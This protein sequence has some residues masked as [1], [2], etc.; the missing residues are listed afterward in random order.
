LR[1]RPATGARTMTSG[2]KCLRRRARRRASRQMGA[3]VHSPSG[4]DP[5]QRSFNSRP[6]HFGGRK[7]ATDPASKETLAGGAKRRRGGKAMWTVLLAPEPSPRRIPNFVSAFLRK[8]EHGP[9]VSPRLKPG[10]SAEPAC[11][12]CFP[13]SPL[14][15]KRPILF[16]LT[17]FRKRGHC[18]SEEIKFAQQRTKKELAHENKPCT[19]WPRRGEA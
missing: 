10:P 18:S 8:R 2:A 7:P 1:L 11:V 5:S 19:Y 4:R 13:R 12:F 9:H 3:C 16:L 6:P 15:Q 14:M 17:N